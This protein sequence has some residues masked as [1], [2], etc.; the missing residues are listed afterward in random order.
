[1]TLY[2]HLLFCPGW[3][4]PLWQA[5]PPSSDEPLGALEAGD[6]SPAT[7]LSGTVSYRCDQVVVPIV[8]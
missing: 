6:R 4:G 1:M 2:P 5:R 3:V 8:I 7:T